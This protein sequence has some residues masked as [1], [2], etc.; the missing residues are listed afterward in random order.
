MIFLKNRDLSFSMRVGLLAC[1]FLLPMALQTYFMVSEKLESVA[2][3]AAEIDGVAYMRPA[4]DLLTAL[5]KPALDPAEV[6]SKAQALQDTGAA[7]EKVL[8]VATETADVVS[9]AQAVSGTSDAGPA[10][11]KTSA[12][13]LAA[14]DKSNL[15]LD[16]DLDTYYLMDALV[17]QLPGLAR[18]VV[19]LRAVAHLPAAEDSRVKLAVAS[20]AVG[21]FTGNALGSIDK[22]IAGN[23]DGTLKGSVTGLR[24][25][26]AAAGDALL[27]AAKSGDAAA[28]DSSAGDVVSASQ[29]LFETMDGDLG[30]LLKVRVAGFYRVLTERLAIVFVLVLVAAWFG[31]VTAR[32][33]VRPIGAMTAAM[34]RL[35]AGDMAT[36]IPA[37]DRHDEIGAMAKAVGIFKD[38]MI[39]ADRLREEQHVHQRQQLE[40]AKKIESS[41]G[42]FQ[43]TV[44]GVVETVSIASADLQE[45]AQAMATTSEETAQRSAT[46]AAA[47]EQATQ[48]VQ[49]VAAATE[50]LSASIR[51]IGSQVSDSSRMVAEAVGQAGRANEK[52][53]GLYAAAQ[54]I[55][56]VVQL[57]TDIAGQTNLLALNAT[58]EAARAGEA[59]KGFAVVASEVKNLANQTAK[60]TEDVGAQIRA[61]QDATR[62]SVKEIQAITETIERVN[63]IASAIASAVEQ[64][65]G[66]TTEIARS[67]QQAAEGTGEVSANITGVRDAAKMS[68][69]AAKQ[70][71]D[72][73]DKLAQNGEILKA[74]VESFLRDVR[75]A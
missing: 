30:R 15:T 6:K 71:L 31:V 36:E 17:N 53:Q 47:S 42:I 8:P 41:V 43:E 48:N 60:A 54:K 22:A 68:G 33:I 12:A 27:A 44:G 34:G 65:G 49:T 70:V 21:N 26:L 37:Q 28:V 57:I 67:V 62:D 46:V 50:E 52:I 59:G 18:K 1:V 72:S 16:P 13:I 24:D 45:T 23:T 69:G 11:E 51:E 73:I 61:I 66:A 10:I 35:A 58:I 55:G 7:L 63:G 19:E 38:K 20:A 3:S 9:G 32:T 40:R 74:Q 75:A 39:E 2:F 4:H 14:S 64:Q 25:K 29:A 56:D 5:G